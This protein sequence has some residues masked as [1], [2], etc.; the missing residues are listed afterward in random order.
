MTSREQAVGIQPMTLSASTASTGAFIALLKAF[1]SAITPGRPGQWQRWGRTAG[2]GLLLA[3]LTTSFALAVASQLG[4]TALSVIGG[5]AAGVAV[6][7]ARRE[8]SLTPA[9][10][11]SALI[12]AGIAGPSQYLAIG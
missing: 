7:L 12:L 1:I 10:P 9:V 11:A 4:V 6:H 5:S 3:L 2:V 8:S